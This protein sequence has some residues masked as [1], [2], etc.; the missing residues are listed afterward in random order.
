MM[1][2]NSFLVILLWALIAASLCAQGGCRR[3]RW[4]TV[5]PVAAYV[6]ALDTIFLANGGRVRGTIMVEEPEFISIRLP[7]GSTKRVPRHEI[8]R[9]AFANGST[10]A[11]F[12]D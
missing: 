8:S 1:K 3:R 11:V 2:K 5:R 6:D 12:S 10:G 4:S 7:D 9:V